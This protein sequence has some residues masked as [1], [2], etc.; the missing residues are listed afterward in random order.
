MRML[1]ELEIGTDELEAINLADLQGL[2]H[3]DAAQKM[4][5]S[6]QTFGRILN[7]ARSKLAMALLKGYAIRINSEASQEH[8]IQI[9]KDSIQ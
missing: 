4:A 3:A 6:R 5:I 1:Q 9:S 7:T 8:I 2:Y